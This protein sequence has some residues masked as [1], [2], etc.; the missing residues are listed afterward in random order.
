[1]ES[2]IMNY[3]QDIINIY[4]NLAVITKKYPERLID[5]LQCFNQNQYKCKTWLVDKLNK[6]PYHFKMK[7]KDSIDIAV[8]GGWYGL[9]AK[10]LFDNFS[11]K[12][13]R[14]IHSY[15]FDPFAKKFGQ[16]LFPVINFH[17]KD[18]K[19][20]QI[21]EKSFSIV[22]NT[23][24]EHIEQKVID[25]TIDK[26]PQETLFVL[27]SNNYVELDQHINCSASLKDFADKYDG[28]LK[29]L[30]MHEL[31]MDQYT[32]FMLIGTKQ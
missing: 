24:C 17:E 28:K 13:I 18:I 27:Q 29:N 14:N 2:T 7:T 15:D 11:I 32:R 23:S 26:A 10:L 16:M 25:Q 22:V 1:M 21:G 4:K 19:D 12:P 8:L 6:Y 20:L 9:T 30:Q 31:D 3:N 5:V